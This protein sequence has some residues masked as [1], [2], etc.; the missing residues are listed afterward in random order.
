M[1]DFSMVESC[2]WGC[3]RQSVS[4]VS[5]AHM[6]QIQVWNA[7]SVATTVQLRHDRSRRCCAGGP[8]SPWSRYENVGRQAIQLPCTYRRG[9]TAMV[10]GVAVIVCSWAYMSGPDGRARAKFRPSFLQ[11]SES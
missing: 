1:T 11:A 8:R 3:S 9:I 5:S 6:A 4:R 10:G 7:H 2:C